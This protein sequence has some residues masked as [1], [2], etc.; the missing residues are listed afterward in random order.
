MKRSK[1]HPSLPSAKTCFG[2]VSYIGLSSADMSEKT[3]DVNQWDVEWIERGVFDNEFLLWIKPD[4]VT[5]KKYRDHECVLKNGNLILK[6]T[7]EKPN[8]MIQY[9][10]P[11]FIR[12]LR[13]CNELGLSAAETK[14]RLRNKCCHI[15]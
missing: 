8:D 3:Y 12:E 9:F 11:D 5:D 1:S 4:S 6:V 2:N 14:K 7:S 10:M 13:K 15:S